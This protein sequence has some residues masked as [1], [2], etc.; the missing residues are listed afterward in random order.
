MD[1][2][3]IR[4]ILEFMEQNQLVEFEYEENGKRIRL[5]K[6]EAAETRRSAAPA[7][8]APAPA[9][10]TTPPRPANQVE[11]TS[12]LVGT[13]YRSPKP[14][15]PPFVRE[16]EEIK[17]DKVLCIV[18]AMKVM[19]EIKSPFEGRIV[20]VLAKDGQAVEFGAPLFLIE[21]K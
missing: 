10:A 18:E 12:P 3:E 21:K 13:F 11:F 7:A 8:P 15:A 9:A 6:G 1:L 16:G 14:G 4:D 2:R 19:N 5:R 20:E 17:P